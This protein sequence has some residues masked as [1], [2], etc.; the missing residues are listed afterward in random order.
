MANNISTHE[1]YL[2][3]LD[4]VYKLASLTADLDTEEI[5]SKVQKGKKFKVDKISMDGLSN[6][7]RINGYTAG[8]VTI[9]QGE[10]E[11]DYDRGTILKVD[12][13]DDLETAYNAFGK[14]AGEFERT[15]A[16]PELDAYRI[17]NYAQKAGLLAIGTVANNEAISKLDTAIGALTDAEVP[18]TDRIL[19]VSTSFYGRLK[20][21]VPNRFTKGSDNLNINRNIEFFDLMPIRVMPASR[22]YAVCVKREKG[23]DNAGAKIN[24]MIV[25]KPAVIQFVKHNA[26]NIIDAAQNQSEDKHIMKYRNYGLATVLDNKANGIYVHAEPAIVDLKVTANEGATIV[27]KETSSEGTTIAGADGIYKLP[28]TISKYYYSVSL[29]G[30]TTQTGVVDIKDSERLKGSSSLAIT[31]VADDGQ[32]D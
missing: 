16:I 22:F 4:E 25:H 7:S 24:F 1:I 19:F 12:A 23:F 17:A 6:Y 13:M 8:D 21:E 10:Y 31:L 11:P 28:T 14:L 18:E 3:A 20:Q 2:D 27:I 26:S 32:S 15:K 30:Y 29:S 9:E 5:N